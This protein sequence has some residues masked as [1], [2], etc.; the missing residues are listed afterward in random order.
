MP[1]NYLDS[2]HFKKNEGKIGKTGYFWGWVPVVGGGQ[3]ERVNEGKYGD[4]SC[5]HI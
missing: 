5:I 3:K 2:I 4:L 1:E